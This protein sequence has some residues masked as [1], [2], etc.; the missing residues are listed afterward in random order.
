MNVI[1]CGGPTLGLQGE[2]RVVR[3]SGCATGANASEIVSY[4]ATTVAWAWMSIRRSAARDPLSEST[5]TTFSIDTMVL[6]GSLP[7]H[8]AGRGSWSEKI[9]LPERSFDDLT[10]SRDSR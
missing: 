2:I 1:C 10:D 7:R 6:R 4:S 3:A 9:T 8:A 5:R